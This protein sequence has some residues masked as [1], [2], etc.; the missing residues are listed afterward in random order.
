VGQKKRKQ[1]A[2]N[3]AGAKKI[4]AKPPSK[5]DRNLSGVHEPFPR[6]TGNRK[7][8]QWPAQKKKPAAPNGGKKTKGRTQTKNQAIPG[9]TT[10][11]GAKLSVGGKVRKKEKRLQP[12]TTNKTTTKKLRKPE[13]PKE[14]GSQKKVGRP[15][16]GPRQ[17]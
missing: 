10:K 4:R 17:L 12:R 13:T 9:G 5:P 1:D 14:K 3:R 2:N 6:E 15:F 11:D 8:T 16:S 7:K